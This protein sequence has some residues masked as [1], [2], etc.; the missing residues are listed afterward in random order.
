M[1]L[2]DF[3]Q[4]LLFVF[5]YRSFLPNFGGIISKK[6][7]DI[8]V[9]RILS[10]VL[11]L[12]LSDEPQFLRI[13]A[14]KMKEIGLSTKNMEL[15]KISK[16]LFERVLL[17]RDDEPQSHRD[18][19]LLLERMALI[20][21]NTNESKQYLEK[22]VGMMY[23]LIIKSWN[24]FDHIEM[25]ICAEINHMLQTYKYLFNKDM[26]SGNY[27]YLSE[28]I[29]EI[30]W[31]VRIVMCW[32]TD[33]TDIDLHVIQPNK[34]EVYYANRLSRIGG[35]NS[36]DVTRG[37][38]PE[39]YR[40]VRAMPGNYEVF[41]KYYASHSQKFTGGTTVL[42]ELYTNYGDIKIENISMSTIRLDIVKEKMLI[43]T[44]KK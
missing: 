33:D 31:D 36:Y 24:Q 29:H 43:G 28:F 12:G 10:N 5:I 26:D 20:L 19:C 4:G 41:A 35:Y 8:I 11:E 15:L 13:I 17:I 38:G 14:Y 34:E 39:E 1:I 21:G 16:I 18:I 3:F 22:A 37:Y 25:N 40:I 2:Q 42:L 23:N 30:K 27:T 7:D 6:I 44:I 9:L 32:D